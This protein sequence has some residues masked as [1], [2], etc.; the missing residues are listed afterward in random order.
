MTAALGDLTVLDLSHARAGPVAR[1]SDT[2]GEIRS[3]TPLLE[4]HTAAILKARLGMSDGDIERLRG[5]RAPGE[6][7]GTGVAGNVSA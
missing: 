5:E 6:L 1:L 7:A 3:P 4:Q 2:P